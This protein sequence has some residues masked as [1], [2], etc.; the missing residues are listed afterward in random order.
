ML[1]VCCVEPPCLAVVPDVCL[2]QPSAHDPP[3]AHRV[4]TVSPPT[5]SSSPP[6]AYPML[7]LET[8]PCAH[9]PPS[10]LTF[11]PPSAHHLPPST[12]PSSPYAHP[13]SLPLD[14]SRSTL[15]PTLSPR[16]VR[17]QT[18]LGPP[19]VLT[20]PASTPPTNYS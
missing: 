4:P 7:S 1:T 11:S 15:P 13:L 2:P 18:T 8:P 12:I 10:V 16:P 9:P 20:T 19:F 14:H 5:G 6:P 3:P 17:L